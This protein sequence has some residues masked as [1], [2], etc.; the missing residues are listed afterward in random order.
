MKRSQLREGTYFRLLSKPQKG[1]VFKVYK[2]R[3]GEE[4]V[5]TFIKHISPYVYWTEEIEGKEMAAFDI[6]YL[7]R[8]AEEALEYNYRDNLKKILK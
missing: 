4:L 5:A 3:P 7:E 2:M 8:V 1:D 6:G